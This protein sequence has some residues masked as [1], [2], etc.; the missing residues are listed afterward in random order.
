[1]ERF[2]E[3]SNKSFEIISNGLWAVLLA[4]THMHK[5]RKTQHSVS[6][7]QGGNTMDSP[8]TPAHLDVV[9]PECDS[10]R[11]P[12]S[13]A[14]D[15]SLHGLNKAVSNLA[16]TAVSTPPAAPGHSGISHVGR[17]SSLRQSSLCRAQELFKTLN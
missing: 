11:R 12:V 13:H 3:G 16:P 10:R 5:R 7:M 15:P 1:M 4:V 9:C 14:S 17:Q 6:Q 2:K 8:D